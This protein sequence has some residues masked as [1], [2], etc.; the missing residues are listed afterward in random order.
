MN[1]SNRRGWRGRIRRN[2]VP[3]LATVGVALFLAAC[4]SPPSGI[5]ATANPDGT[6]TVSWTGAVS[7]SPLCTDIFGYLVEYGTS[8]G[9]ETVSVNPTEVPGTSYLPG[10][11]YDISTTGDSVTVTNLA[12]ATTYYF[13]VVTEGEWGGEAGSGCIGGTSDELSATT[14]GTT[15]PASTTCQLPDSLTLTGTNPTSLPGDGGD[16]TVVSDPVTI[17]TGPLVNCGQDYELYM[18]DSQGGYYIDCETGAMNDDVSKYTL[19]GD[20]ISV[21]LYPPSDADCP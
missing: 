21:T 14:V 2:L 10:S 16:A 4:T 13:K 6:I 17:S 20:T 7:E 19:I 15:T 5:S 1:L 12:P 9:A 8:P 18:E 3:G 11:P